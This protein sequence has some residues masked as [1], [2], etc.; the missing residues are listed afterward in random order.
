MK[1]PLLLGACLTTGSL[2]LAADSAPV[3][4]EKD[5]YPSVELPVPNGVSLEVSALEILPNGVLMVGTRR[6][7][8]YAVANPGA[9]DLTQVKFT[10]YASGMHE[11][12]GL[13]YNAK[14]KCLYVTQ[15]PEITRTK[16]SDGD[17]I[18]DVYE[19][20]YDGWGQSGDY[21]EYNFGSR[22][23]KEGNIWTVLCL[24]GS[25][26][27]N[28]EW[29]GW[30][31][32]ISPEGKMIPTCG[33]VRSP[34]GIGF[35]GGNCFYTDNQGPWNGSSSLK[36]LKPGSFA[37]HD[38]G[39]KWYAK[40]EAKAAMG[41]AVPQPT[42]KSR[43]VVERTKV[44]QLI[45]P[46]VILPH[47]RV[48]QSTSGFF[49][50][51]TAGKFGPFAGQV[52]VGD[53]GHSN[54]VRCPLETVNGVMQGGCIGFR[55]GFRC[56]IIPALQTADGTVYIGGADRGWGS[57]GGKPYTLE[58]LRWGGKVPFELLDIKAQ[59]DGFNLTFTEPVDAA[60]AA[61]VASYKSEAWTY[62]YQSSY[63]SPE[64]DKVTP[65]VESATVSADGKSVRLKL[66]PLTKGH[67]HMIE[68][69]GVKSKS[70]TGLL[71]P[72]VYYTLNEIPS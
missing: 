12:L 5:Y 68:F 59:K 41:E 54:L 70:G 63:G 49:E 42:D 57:K 66:S 69:P 9:E 47:G 22:F 32:R 21:H 64:V 28:V 50:D 2:A 1:F 37:G 43:M 14:D 56:G 61:N 13:A 7:D 48:G 8:I 24:T 26:S 10:R 58:R 62:I 4:T 72:K 27:S 29:R 52:F 25:F 17:G 33:G 44:P 19:T 46:V 51:T 34:G 39:N 35:I 23:D 36:Y 67:V 40:P 18:C 6:G 31:L 16:D 3:L 38:G 11:I 20:C 55:E 65:V 45:P 53:Q 60:S 15:R 30:C 71:H